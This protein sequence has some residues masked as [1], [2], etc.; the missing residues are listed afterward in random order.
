[1]SG[2][3]EPAG[4]LNRA[5]QFVVFPAIRGYL[6]GAAVEMVVFVSFGSAGGHLKS[7]SGFDAD[8]VLK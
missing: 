2:N 7:P 1:L 5:E 8:E 6:V 3:A 4:E